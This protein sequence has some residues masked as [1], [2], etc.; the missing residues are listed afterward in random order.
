MVFIQ[1]TRKRK[2]QL[3][4]GLVKSTETKKMQEY[5][6]TEQI[7]W[8]FHLSRAQWQ[9]G[10]LER[11]VGLVK[12]SLF[13]ATGRANLTK[14]ELDENLLDLE[15]VLNNR[16]LICIEEDIQMPVLTPNTLLY[17][18]PNDSRKAIR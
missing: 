4:S 2:L 7:K 1:T 12:P 9:G 6:I 15:I 17:G 5:L 18:Q 14:Q 11:M 3:Q 13:K 16:P 8:K 10:Q